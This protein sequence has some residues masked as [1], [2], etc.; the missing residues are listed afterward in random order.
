MLYQG[1]VRPGKKIGKSV[2]SSLQG[3]FVILSEK[4][5]KYIQK[6]NMPYW[7]EIWSN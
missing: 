1:I 3:N 6:G 7:R 5:E 4:I 2:I